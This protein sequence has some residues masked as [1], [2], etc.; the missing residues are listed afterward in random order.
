MP[1]QGE[2]EPQ[3]NLQAIAAG[4]GVYPVEAYEFVRRGLS[5]TVEKIPH[6]V[7]TTPDKTRHVTGRQLCE[8]LREFALLNGGCSPAPF[9]AA[10]NITATLDFGEVNG[11]NLIQSAQDMLACEEDSIDDFRN[12]YDFKNA[13]ESGYRIAGKRMK[14]PDSG[15]KPLPPFKPRPKALPH[16]LD[17]LPDLPG[18]AAAHLFPDG[19]SPPASRPD[20][21]IL[22]S[23]PAID[24]IA[25]TPH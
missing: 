13:F 11:F 21:E 25:K 15:F 8:G 17:P 20:F 6:G 2:T 10:G 19:L 9:F 22:N 4:F 23:P 7:I 18:R 5:F 14:S 12:V 24:Y 3:N 16:A 1:P